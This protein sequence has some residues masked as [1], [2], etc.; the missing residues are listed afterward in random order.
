MN[1]Y[2]ELTVN[3]DQAIPSY[4][5][6]SAV[7]EQIH[8]AL[9]SMNSSQIGISF[10]VATNKYIGN[11]IRLH[12]SEESLTAIMAYG[13]MQQFV[14]FIDYSHV[15]D[16]PENHT[17]RIVSRIQIKSVPLSRVHRY[18]KRHN[19]SKEV[20]ESAL[21]SNTQSFSSSF[22]YIRVMSQ[23]TG[24]KVFNLAINQ[25]KEQE[26]PIKGK[27]NAYGLSESATIPWFS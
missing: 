2:I 23:S 21:K 22:P 17:H 5:L 13:W 16:I 14:G 6:M 8:L 24:G 26:E 11:K 25:Q 15:K 10:P 3:N 1:K 19:V 27:F 9:V 12:G 7:F 20:A 4:V 18:M